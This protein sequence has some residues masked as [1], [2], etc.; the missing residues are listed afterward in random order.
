M[1]NI[2]SILNGLGFIESETNTYLAMLE[3]GPSTVIDISKKTSLSRQATYLS[4]K[5]LERRGLISNIASGKKNLFVA[6]PP[7]KLLAYAK[8]RSAEMNNR[9]GE[10]EKAVPEL[11]LWSG[12]EKPVVRVFEGKEGIRAIMEEI[13]TATSNE[14]FEITDAEALYRALTPDDLKP[15]RKENLLRGKKTHTLYSGEARESLVA[16]ERVRLPDKFRNFHANIGIYGNKI[17]MVT[18][19][20]KMYSLIIESQAL[21]KTLKILFELSLQNQKKNEKTP[22]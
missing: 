7:E 10:L 16:S 21:T 8:R 22:S 17:V 2:S 3:L 4:I 6:E 1:I 14:I 18:F 9:I 15:V 5:T 12:G 11:V 20:G 19:E 13:S